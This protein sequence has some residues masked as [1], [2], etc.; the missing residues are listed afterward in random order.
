M[1]KR[2]NVAFLWHMHQPLYKDPSN[3]EYTLPWV[4][5]HATKDYYDMAAILDEFPSV[6]QTF[7]LVPCLIE[8]INEYASGKARDKYRLISAKRA[9]DLTGEDKAFIL[10]F[11]FQANWDNM[12][13][14]IARY[15]ELLR[16][17]GVSNEKDEVFQVLR[18]FKEQDFLDLQVLYNLIWIDPSIR[19]KDSFLSQLIR[20]G[21]SFT[22]EEKSK[23]LEKQL[24]IAGSIISKYADLRDR[25]IIE[26]STSPYYH[27][28]LPLLCDSDSAKEAMPGATLPKT[29]FQHPEDALAQVRK[30]VKLYQDTFGEKPRGMWPSEGSVSMEMLPLVVG[31]GIQWIATDEEI[32]S[33]SLR[34]PVRRDH[35]GNCFD[36]FLYKPYEIDVMGRKITV[37]FRDHVLSDLIGF[38]YA[39]MDPAEAA[40]DMVSRLV[41]I[42]NMLEDPQEHLVSIILDGENAW[43]HFRNDGRDFLAALYTKLSDHPRLRCV[44][45]SEFIDLKTRREPLERLYPGSWISHNFKIWIGHIEDNTAWDYISEAREEL[46][47]YEKEMKGFP[48]DEGREK[49]I[50]EAWEEVYASEG[51]DWFW[52]YGEEHSSMSDEDFD[53]LFRRHIKRIYQ[54]IEKEPPDHLDISISSDIRSYRPPVEP[55]ALIAPVIDGQISNYFEWLSSGRLE[56]TYF[57]SAMHKEIQGGLIDSISY[58]FSKDTLYLRLD[59]LEELGSFAHP[60]SFTI[61]FVQP[62][63]VRVSATVEGAMATAELHVK[64]DG[65]EKWTAAGPLEIASETVVELAIPLKALGAGR[66]EEL[67]LFI[68]I[69]AQE[70]GIERWPVKGYL[71][72]SIPPEDFEQQDW[73]V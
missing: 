56:R 62:R 73:L 39:R 72:F 2:L 32:L 37:V 68:T 71:L 9:S 4:L 22:E 12:I 46:V 49:A 66:G 28:I 44:S 69:N 13:K 50:R 26:V 16:K 33:N 29:R 24:E 21:G 34:R 51:S 14:P 35:M 11:F 7:N 40:S 53:T 41:H 5:F 10:Q 43:E 25:G 3:G 38:D 60:W 42:S 52:W 47:R 48:P 18:Y 19:Q 70:R 65:K 67:K 6:H 54:L 8:Q 57:G 59:Y 64:A 30:G 20:K 23:L 15:W 55:R 27:P 58:G 45:M 1:D 61:S 31:E 36:S 63:P 17:R